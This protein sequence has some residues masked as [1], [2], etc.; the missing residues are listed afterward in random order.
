MLQNLLKISLQQF[1]LADNALTYWCQIMFIQDFI[2]ASDVGELLR[3]LV[4]E[5]T[6]GARDSE[7]KC[8]V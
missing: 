5:S 6:L 7:T 8:L 1:V 3:M 4:R 2:K